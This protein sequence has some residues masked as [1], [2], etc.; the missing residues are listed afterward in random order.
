MKFWEKNPVSEIQPIGSKK[1]TKFFNQKK[2]NIAKFIH[3]SQLKNC[4]LFQLINGKNQKFVNPIN[5]GEKMP[6]D[7]KKI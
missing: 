4:K 6:I 1:V 3:W 5:R 7:K 2:E